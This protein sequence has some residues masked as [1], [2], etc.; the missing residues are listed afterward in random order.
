MISVG[1]F[2]ETTVVVVEV[3]AAWIGLVE[4]VEFGIVVA[5]VDLRP[6]HPDR[7]IDAIKNHR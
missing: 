2:S 7:S 6:P 5:V 4:A 1:Q 3:V